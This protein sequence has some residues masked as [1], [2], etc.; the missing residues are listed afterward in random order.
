MH[1]TATARSISC[2]NVLTPQMLRVMKLTAILLFAACLHVSARTHGQVISL[3][4]K[5]KPLEQVLGEIKRQSGFSFIYGKELISK[6]DPVSIEVKDQPLASVLQLIFQNQKLTYNITDNYVVISPKT[7]TLPPT[8]NFPN[9]PGSEPPAAPLIDISGKVVDKDINPLVGATIKIKGHEKKWTIT[10]ANGIFTLKELKADDVLVISYVG[11]DTKEIPI[12][13]K[14][15]GFIVI[16]LKLSENKLD[17]VQTIA[18][19][20]TSMRYNTGDITTI[21]AKEIERNPVSN[22]LQALQGRVAGMFVSEQT[23]QVNGGF[24]VQIRSLNTLSG[25]ARTSPII[26]PAGGQPLYIVDGVEYPA[27]SSLPMMN[28]PGIANFQLFGNA[29]NYLDP[30][31][32]ESINIL[33]GPDA[34]SIYGSRGAFG[35]II[36]TTKKAKASKPSL[37]INASYGFSAVGK[38]PRMMNTQEYLAMRHNALANDNLTAGPTDYDLNGTWDTTS[39]NNW[40]DFFLGDHAP[41]SRLNASYS[42]GNAN[43]NFLIGANYSYTGNIQRSKGSVRAGG[44]NFSMNTATNDRKLTTALSGSYSTNTNDMVPVDFAGSG[45]LSMAPNA[46]YPFLPD[47]K[48]NWANGSNPAAALNAIYNNTTDNLIANI[49]LNYTPVKGLSFVASGGYNLLWA[50][51]FNALPSSYFN[52]ATFTPAQTY[53]ALNLYRIRTISADPRV[54]FTRLLWGKGYLSATVGGSLRDIVQDKNAVSGSGFASDQLLMNPTLA[55]AANIAT[56]Y[57]FAPKRYIGGFAILNFRWA[58]KYILSVNGRRDGS[59]VFGNNRQFGNFGSVAG[60]WIISEEPWF[61]RLRNVISFLKLKASYGLVGG[62]AIGPYAYINTYGVSSNTYGGGLSLTP[63]NLAN[64]YL[65]W[66]TNRN[67]EVGLTIDLFKGRINIDG[68]YYFNKV[69]DQLINQPL[70]S[71]TGFTQFVVNSPANINSYGA[72]ITINTKNIS[73]ANFS[74][75]TRV[76]VTIPRTKLISYPGIDNLV[77]NVNYVIGKPITGI[78]LFNYAGVDPA[79]GMYHFYNADGVK[80]EFNP[81]FSPVQLS[82]AKDRTAFVD[83]APKYYGGILNMLSYKNLSIDFLV[84][85]TNRMGPDYLAYQSFAMGGVN[86]NF[87]ADIASRRWMKPGDNAKVAKATTSFLSLFNQGNFINSTGA[88]TNATYARLQNVSVSY[89]FPAKLIKPMRMSALSVYAAGQNLFTLSKFNNLDP[90]SMLSGRMPPLR[91][92]TIGLNL[93]F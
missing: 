73:N 39:F 83:L 7:I 34:T 36:I 14:T 31:L 49:S 10:N 6:A 66:E 89:R 85:I 53:S 42:G 61:K 84:T 17:E 5:N 52:P 69:G 43:T 23:G 24:Q 93:T 15:T 4:V 32:I 38:M 74:W 79:T 76:N 33:K 30:S 78:K 91:A 48:L 70:S 65:H 11:Y 3:S 55:N 51:E 22:V 9:E 27:S 56:V 13:D 63:Q 72:E 35:V 68:I 54:E 75:N 18:Y 29:L 71:I 41:T 2:R 45:G 67:K 8:N 46:P 37:N 40:E 57:S 12:K 92:Y 81:I 26:I 16:A 77:S 86:R 21:S 64:P 60:G 19:S 44:V 58:E 90:E 88:Y 82:N 62:S 87:P 47:G 25:G 80:G 20:K 1:L 59:S 28:L 50:K